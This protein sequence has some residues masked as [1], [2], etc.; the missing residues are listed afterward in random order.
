[1]QPATQERYEAAQDAFLDWCDTLGV[2]W[3]ALAEEQQDFVLAD[4]VL[5][6]RESEHRVQFYADCLASLQKS[7]GHRRHFKA[8]WK[9]LEGWR[10][11]QPPVQAPPA[12]ESFV[13]ASVTML[14]LDDQA[15]VAIAILIAFCGVLRISE[16]LQ[17]SPSDVVCTPEGVVLLL[18]TT[19][20]GAPQSDRV[21][22]SNPAVVYLCRWRLHWC[23]KNHS[24]RLCN[25]SYFTVGKS[26]QLCAN[27]FGF[28]HVRFTTH[29]L[30]RGGATALYLH[31]MPF[32]DIMF[33]GRW[34]SESS[35]KLYI[36]KAD[37]LAM[38]PLHGSVCLS[39]VGCSV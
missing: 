25:V 7:Y 11:E 17:L 10:S 3:H 16:A 24:P 31:G 34:S 1:M 38:R 15:G 37:V 35:A 27:C 29:S 36:K 8:S 22:L 33:F 28:G 21:V 19:K 6:G 14:L 26:L 32:A 20:R 4:Y 30:R 18:R 9:V 23:R 5:D 13:Y 12:P 39:V 2:D